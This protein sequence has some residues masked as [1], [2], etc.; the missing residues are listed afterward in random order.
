M[1]EAA[2]LERLQSLTT[3][4]LADACL[5]RRAANPRLG[6]REH[7]RAVGRAIEE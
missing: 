6:F 1:T 4:H 5:A 3:P 2:L 7:L